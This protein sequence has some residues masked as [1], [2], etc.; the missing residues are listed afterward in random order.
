MVTLDWWFT[1]DSMEKMNDQPNLTFDGLVTLV[2]ERLSKVEVDKDRFSIEKIYNEE[3]QNG[4]V[5]IKFDGVDILRLH[6]MVERPVGGH[7][8]RALT[9]V[10][11]KKYSDWFH[12]HLNWRL[13]IDVH[14]NEF[15]LCHTNT[16]DDIPLPRVFDKYLPLSKEEDKEQIERRCA[17]HGLKYDS[18]LFNTKNHEYEI[19][20]PEIRTFIDSLN[21]S[22]NKESIFLYK[23][24]SFDTLLAMLEHKTFRIN[25]VVAM[26]DLDE[27]LWAS[28]MVGNSLSSRE[29]FENTISNKNILITSLTDKYDDAT[30][31]RLY[32]NK[33]CGAFITFKI[34]PYQIRKIKYISPDD[35]LFRKLKD[36]SQR[37]GARG[38]NI[39]FNGLDQDRYFIKSSSYSVEG[40]YRFMIDTHDEDL[41][42][43]NYGG[44]L[45]PYRDFTYN[46]TTMKFDGLPFEIVSITIGHNIPYYMTNEPLLFEKIYRTFPKVAIYDSGIQSLR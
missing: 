34:P 30:M 37:M 32:A 42:L 33:G 14:V 29:Y 6:Y 44:L 21:D 22:L 1:V 39:N 13:D 35:D 4:I 2:K 23:Y 24:I 5:S 38:I 45:S 11:Y 3:Y 17:I 40:E 12:N 26:N 20:V 7:S 10:H 8:V 31:W 28:V 16:V 41:P 19:E 15:S 27:T 46:P 9:T 25:S 43:A 18:I 36:V